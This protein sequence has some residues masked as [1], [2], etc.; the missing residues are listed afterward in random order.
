MFFSLLWTN[1]SWSVLNIFLSLSQVNNLTT[2]AKDIRKKITVPCSISNAWDSLSKPES[3]SQ[4]LLESTEFIPEEGSKI[5][6]K[7]RKKEITGEVLTAQEPINLAYS[8]VDPKSDYTTYVWWKL[9]ERDGETL[10][11]LDHSGFKG[12]SGAFTSFS[13]ASFWS[14]KLRKLKSHLSQV[15]A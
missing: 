1:S 15:T 2:M 5:R 4:W 3:I 10:I 7:D 13:Y 12:I 8:W 14:K 6:F 11:E 9:L